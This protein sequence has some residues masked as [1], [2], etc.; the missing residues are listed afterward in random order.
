MIHNY[1]E[2]NTL[3]LTNKYFSILQLALILHPAEPAQTIMIHRDEFQYGMF[4]KILS[5]IKRLFILSN[6]QYSVEL[7][8]LSFVMTKCDITK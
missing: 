1:D 6:L 7:N 3:L 8:E 4:L 2:V 5:N